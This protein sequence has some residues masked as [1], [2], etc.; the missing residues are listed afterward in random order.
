MRSRAPAIV[1]ADTHLLIVE[2][3]GNSVTLGQFVSVRGFLKVVHRVGPG[4]DV[5]CGHPDGDKTHA[6]TVGKGHPPDVRFIAVL[7]RADVRVDVFGDGSRIQPE[8]SA[9]FLSQ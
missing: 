6:I 7:L 1:A 9:G 2:V 3:D 5:D 8:C 4:T